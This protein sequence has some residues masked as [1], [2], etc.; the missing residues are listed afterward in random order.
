MTERVPED[1]A[2]KRFSSVGGYCECCGKKLIQSRRGRV[3]EGAWEA[4]HR[5]P[6]R[7]IT[8]EN[9]KIVCSTGVNC[10]FKCCHWGSYQNYPIWSCCNRWK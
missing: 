3:G 10:H 4:H 6:D 7:P 8:F 9:I 2:L 1:I 5:F